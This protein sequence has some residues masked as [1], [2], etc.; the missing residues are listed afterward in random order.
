M[1]SALVKFKAP[2]IESRFHF[3]YGITEKFNFDSILHRTRGF[4]LKI[5]LGL[6]KQKEKGE[7]Y[8]QVC[9]FKNQGNMSHAPVFKKIM[10]HT[11]DY[12]F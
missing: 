8:A 5:F 10:S 3:A 7:S 11:C 1:K 6:K 9:L 12:F 2:G 4:F